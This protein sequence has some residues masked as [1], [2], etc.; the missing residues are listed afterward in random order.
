MD[1]RER[2]VRGDAKG[3]QAGDGKT[4]VEEI[5]TRFPNQ[6]PLPSFR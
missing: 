4:A 1:V 5:T 2:G 3:K 6:Y